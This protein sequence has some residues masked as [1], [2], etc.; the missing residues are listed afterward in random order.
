MRFAA[1]AY[2]AVLLAGPGLAWSQTPGTAPGSTPTPPS[3]STTKPMTAPPATT[4]S[5]H[6]APAT[7]ALPAG[8]YAVES[9][10]KG[11]CPTDTVVWAN[12]SSKA[13]HM[14]GTK[15]YGKTKHGAY[16]CQKDADQAGYHGS[17]PGAVAA[18]KKPS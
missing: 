12:T 6:A 13:Y 3:S 10:A 1:A 2:L 15:Y 7:T 5:T 14:S 11:H 4:R 17:K 9:E 8:G 18:K 16:M